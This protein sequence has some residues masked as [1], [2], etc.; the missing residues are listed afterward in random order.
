MADTELKGLLQGLFSDVPVETPFD[1]S[2]PEPA[3]EREDT[4]AVKGLSARLQAVAEVSRAASSILDDQEL[5]PMAASLIRDQF[6]LYYVGIYQ[7][8][9]SGQLAE[10]RAATGAAGRT[11]IEKGHK[12]EVGGDSLIGRCLESTQTCIA[13]AANLAAADGYDRLL[14]ETRA[15]IA[16]PL[17]SRGHIIGAVTLQATAADAFGEQ[18][19]PILQTMADQLASA[20]ANARLFQEQERRVTELAMV[21]EIGQAIAIAIDV[22][23]LLELIHLQVSRLFDATNFYIATYNEGADTWTSAFHVEAGQQQ[24]PA[25]HK[26]EA[27]LTGFIIRS[28]QPLLFRSSEEIRAH[29]QAQELAT[30]GEIACSWLGVPLVAADKLVG[31]MA[32]QDY[33]E[34]NLYGQ[35]DQTLLSTI[36]AQVANTLEN[37]RLLEETRRQAQEMQVINQVG[38]TATSVHDPEEV[39][40]QLVDAAKTRLGH[41][42]VSIALIEDGK[43]VFRHGSPI[44]DSDIRLTD[45]DF[46]VDLQDGQGLIAEAARSGQPVLVDNVL[47]DPRYLPIEGLPNTRSELAVPIKVKGRIIGTLDVQSRRTSAYDNTD[48]ALLQALASQAGVAIENARLHQETQLALTRTRLQAERLASLNELS[49]ELN[50]AVG[51]NQV[52]D[53][54][55]GKAAELFEADRTRVTMLTCDG[56]GF[57]ISALRGL[58]ADSPVGSVLPANEGPMARSVQE[59]RLVIDAG[60]QSADPQGI[61]SCMA[62]PLIT[63]EGAVGTLDVGKAQA[64]A[65]GQHDGE[66]LL[67]MAALLSS[68]IENKRLLA[69]AQRRVNEM[70]MLSNLSQALADAPLQSEEIAAIVCRQFVDEMGISEASISL[71]DPAS[72][73]LNILADIVVEGTEYQS[74]HTPES[75]HLDDYPATARVL[76]T[77]RPE[78][79]HASDPNADPAELAYME[80]Y[81]K[82]TLAILPLASKGQAMGVIELEEAN[83]EHHFSPEEI[84]LAATMASQA[85]VALENARL[86]QQS[87]DFAE[88]QSTLRRIT[89][90]VSRSLEMQEL[91]D[92]ALGVT[93]TSLGFDAGL[94]SLTD[95]KTGH[96]YLAVHQGLP[97][98]LARKLER[99]GLESTLCD[100]VLQ[101]GETICIADVRQ[102][103]PVDVT[104]VIAQGLVAYTGTPLVYMG[105]RVGTICFFNRSVKD[106]NSRELAL[107]EAIGNQIGVGVANSRLL[108]Q[109]QRR[110]EEQAILNEIG[111]TLTAC[112]DVDDVLEE[113]HRGTSLLLEAENYYL[114]LYDSESNEVTLAWRVTDGH[115]QRPNTTLPLEVGGLAE[116]L[117]SSRQ[118]L[119]LTHRQGQR[120]TELGLEQSPLQP[121]LPPASWL[122]VPLVVGDRALGTIV[123][124]SYSSP[125]LYDEH[126]QELLVALASRTAVSLENIRLLEQTRAALAK[127]EATHQSY[128]RHGWQQHLQQREG[129]V[130]SAFLYDQTRDGQAEAMTEPLEIQRPEIKRAVMDGGPAAVGDGGDDGERSGLAIPISIRGQT[131][132]VVGVESPSGDRQWTEEDVAFVQA[133]SEQLGQTL[134]SARLFAETQRRA[135]RERLIG[136]ITA[137]IRSS[138]DMHDIL[139]T[140]AV[141]LG[142]ALGTSRALIRVGLEGLDT[143]EPGNDSQWQATATED[144][145]TSDTDTE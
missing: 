9:E 138:T 82:E 97:G 64:R 54:A 33:K 100:H 10:L 132:G 74:E 144:G 102:G 124:A 24:P 93:L 7:M 109:A 115:S 35:E 78:I 80:K 59:H 36:A 120:M 15:E 61:R 96:L 56:E 63:A 5:L 117:L 4:Q 92:T 50:R 145:Y 71:V 125:D 90:A 53:I 22:D 129:L 57:E 127:V 75:F 142:Q 47:D 40:R 101:T 110:A 111:Q 31:V 27:G 130:Q 49:E 123:V 108:R 112:Q 85:A 70:T 38:Q 77:L 87:E 104:G 84:S 12:L 79:V 69:E 141:E 3:T 48:L 8:D 42:F 28:R 72:G 17:L 86:F 137:K 19:L 58:D 14:P 1:E 52:L 13:S 114:T 46:A 83:Q 133:I 106:M 2:V 121:G 55:A 30:I 18:D 81:E 44:G 16:L 32:I 113:T 26:T 34:E 68:A 139:E 23:E 118:P 95:E 131:I 105:D 122:G 135:E 29:L 43:L 60:Q 66:V 20:I 45:V 89:E 41:Y 119:L 103:A 6:D 116:Y 51:L 143:D 126:S 91:L 140:A 67:Q 88:E 99:D 128:V 76:Q 25:Q 39:L 73:R 65:Y 94:V 107:L 136:D 98:P 134:E 37:L 62:A 11:M 21:N